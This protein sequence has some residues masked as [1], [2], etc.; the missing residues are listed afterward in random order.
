MATRKKNLTQIEIILSLFL[1]PR[2]CYRAIPLP[3]K[4]PGAGLEPAWAFKVP[5]DFKSCASANFAIP[6]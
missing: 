3:K 4:M 5:Q 1:S 6:A 2:N